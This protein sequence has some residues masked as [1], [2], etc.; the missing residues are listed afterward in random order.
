MSSDKRLVNRLPERVRREDTPGVRIDSGPFI[1]IIRNNNDP[2]RAGRLQVWIPDLGGKSDDPSSWR[3]VSYASPFYGTTFQPDNVQ[4]NKFSDVSHSYGMWAVVPDI[5]NQVICTFIAG[6]P[7]RGF[8]FA[9]IN[10]NLSHH[11]V[12]AMGTGGSVDNNL[13]T[14]GLK[15]KYDP[16]TSIWPVAEFNENSTGAI[17]PGWTNN[18]KPV[19]EFQA[20][21][22][23][24]QGL[25]RDGLRGAIGSSSQ[26]ESPSTVFGISTP[27]RPLNDPMDNPQYQAKLK[28]GTLTEADTAITGRKGGHT[29]VM[30]DG[31]STGADQLMRLRTAGGHQLLMNDSDRVVYLANS[32]GSV[33]LEFT[34]GGHINVFSAAGINMRTDGE[35]NLHA[36]KDIN[37]H[38]GGSIKMKADVSINSQAKDYTIKAGNSVGIQSGKVGVL[39]DGA[40]SLQ[41]A[42][43][44]WLSDGKLALQGS[45]VLLNTEAPA[46]VTPVA[47]IKT[48]KQTDTGWDDK[49]GI[50]TNQADVFESIATITPSH[51]PWPRG[52]GKGATK[53]A[54]SQFAAAPQPVKPTSV[55]APPGQTLPPNINNITP[56]GGSNEALLE[57]T[58]TG[59]G[60]TDRIQIAA[61]MAQCAHESGNFQFL[62]EL[63]ADSY[64]QKYEGRRDL[65]NTQPGDG[66]KYKGRGF[67]QITGRDLYTQ[68]GAYLGID[69]VNQPQLA[70]DPATAAKLVLFFFFQFKKSRTAGVDWSDVTAVTRIVNGGTNGLPDRVAKFSAYQQKYTN[71]IVTTGSGGV[72][73]DGSGNPVTTGST[74]LDPGPDI[75][76]SKPVV[77]PAPGETMKKQDAPNPGAITSTESKI[78]GLIP[79][80]MKALMIE[81]GFAESNSDYAAQD[82]D[83]SR[84]GRY[85][86]N[87]NLLRDNG[88]IKSDYVKKYKGAAIFQA[89][90]WTGKDGISDAA[91]F[92]SAKGTQ[93][94]LMEKIL[95]DYYTS[96][97]SNRG[98]QIEDDVCTVAG[99]MSVAYFLRDSERGFFSGNPP[100]Q[101]KFWR[102]QGNNITNE[103]K[104]TPDT[105]YN[106]G[107]Y[108]IDVL[109]IS[110]AGASSGTVGTVTPSTTGIDPNEVFTFTNRS[111]DAAHFDVATVDF[112]DRLLQ[113]ARDYKAATGKKVTISSTVRTQEEQTS[114][115]DGW[116]AA[117]GQ[118]PGNPTVNVTPYGNIS[119]PVKTVGNHGLGIAA[120]IGVADAIAME[121]M[122]ILAK[123]G[124][125]RFDPAGDPPHIQLK[126]ELRP[127][128]LATI[129][130]LPGN[131]TA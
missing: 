26:R 118:L 106:Q 129:Q 69:L 73:T 103:Q 117:G 63:G 35:F 99:M 32:D 111:G 108:A 48:N 60:L 46:A 96:L 28:A 81:I 50:W 120:D 47:D 113:A 107:R 78:P 112:K 4:N 30:D 98:I 56:S 51:E 3:T 86:F 122:G 58:L 102:E 6:D 57:S 24:Q 76:K 2:T 68:A 119:R 42:N 123:Y 5:G 52:P 27:G 84:I 89:G 71:G 110:T 59:Y 37:M 70:A 13:T 45:K 128:N 53:K 17:K 94:T 105:A 18:P 93:D 19:H 80:Q 83:L 21:I 79:T 14:A 31:S 33:W 12:P 54:V 88:Y 66:L 1:G 97:V 114:I 75:A 41:S 104:Q 43:G 36:G 7:N 40:L 22:L 61:I 67:I 126:P 25:D 101:A 64:F 74:K 90:A 77:S 127:A 109:S 16:N 124:L 100:D 95:N 116:I 131:S 39:A 91:G 44:G 65:G 20:N 9:C 34:G 11:M 62:T 125:Y 49:K 121:S 10:P 92:A 15:E 55:C 85:A 130:S 72:L 115:Y 82:T 38:S 8:W 29:F 23:I 87:A